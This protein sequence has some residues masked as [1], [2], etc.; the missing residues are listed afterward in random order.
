MTSEV[1]CDVPGCL[2]E[3]PAAGNVR[4]AARGIVLTLC[5]DDLPLLALL[6][7]A[8]ELVEDERV[9]AWFHAQDRDGVLALLALWK[10][11]HREE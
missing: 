10:I 8:A 7:G 4:N 1:L 11:E 3:A 5:I 2:N 6:D 9:G